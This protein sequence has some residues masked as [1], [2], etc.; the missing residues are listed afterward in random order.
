MSEMKF[1]LV[2]LRV[3]DRIWRK[4]KSIAAL[5]GKSAES[6]VGEILAQWIKEGEGIDEERRDVESR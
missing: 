3:K 4:V 2:R 1:R 5:R 6:L